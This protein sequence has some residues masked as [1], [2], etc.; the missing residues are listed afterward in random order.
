[1]QISLSVFW[2]PEIDVQIEWDDWILY[3]EY[4]TLKKI[5]TQTLLHKLKRTNNE[6]A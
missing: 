6:I 1:M 2:M 4:T 5:A 3:I